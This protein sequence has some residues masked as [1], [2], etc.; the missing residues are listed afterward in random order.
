MNK[1][2]TIILCAAALAAGGAT[3]A[4]AASQKY[5]P[6][7]GVN[8]SPH[9][10][11]RIVPGGDT[12][13]TPGSTDGRVCAYCHTPHHAIQDPTIANYNPLWSHKVTTGTF[14]AYKS[15]TLDAKIIDPLIG[16]SRL[17]MSC[18][19][20]VIAVD[21]HY[22]SAIKNKVIATGDIFG[23]ID[24]GDANGSTLTND[25]PVGFDFDA[26][27]AA[28]QVGGI[29]KGIFPGTRTFTVNLN[30]GGA[31]SL[32]GSFGLG[33][34]KQFVPSTFA[35]N[36]NAKGGDGTAITR[37]ISD[38]MWVNTADGKNY[39]TCAS[40]HDVHNKENPEQYLLI[41]ME[42]NSAICLTCH[43]K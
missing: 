23:G 21:Q 7:E 3:G 32:A 40:C 15:T 27:A 20:G 4:Y 42:K 9:N 36:M 38:L 16:P 29:Y 22:G 17:C 28:N 43:N 31:G 12:F 37:S 1:K 24:V 41:N 2:L 26:A 6:A 25:H 5:N 10:I 11:N 33:D 18:H 19:D 13:D 30:A 14:T 39:M 8:K 34:N 35:G